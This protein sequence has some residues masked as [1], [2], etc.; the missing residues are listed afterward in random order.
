MYTRKLKLLANYFNI[1]KSNFSLKL[2]LFI[3][4]LT[5]GMF[6][7]FSQTYNAPYDI[8]RFQDFIGE[9]K[10]QA[11]TSSTAATQSD[12][13]NGYSSNW[14]YVVDTDKVAF[15]QSGSS[16]RTELRD[17]RNW[18]ITQG[19][20]SLFGR[21]D[22]VNQTCD[23]VTVLQI[24][25]DANAGSGPN[26]PL[27]RIYKHQNKSP[28]NHIWAAIKTDAGGA[29]TTHVDLGA[30]P[31]GYF[32]CEIKLVNGNMIINFDGVEKVNMDIS[33]WTFP[34]YWKAGV[35]LQDNG[36]ATAYFDQLYTG[37]PSGNI[38][39][40]VSISSPSNGTSFAEG[41][42]VTIN[43][44]AVDTDGTISQVEFFANGSSIGVDTSSP[45]ST[46][47]IIGL[48]SYDITAVATDNESLSTTSSIVTIT[49]NSATQNTDMYVSNI[50][51]GTQNAGKGSKYGIATVTILDGTGAPVSGA[52]VTGTFS[53]TFNET[54]SGIT[55]NNG[56]ITLIT[57]TT[58]KG[59]VSVDLCVDN[60]THSTLVYNNSLN[61]ITCTG[62]A[63]MLNV[64]S[65][66]SSFQSSKDLFDDSVIVYP[67][68]AT[69]FFEV[70]FLLEKENLFG[71]RVFGIDGREVIS[72]E[73]H[74]LSKDTH[75]MN[76]DI[77]ELNS[78]IYFL[79]MQIGQKILT[80]RI[81]KE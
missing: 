72:I 25:D 15:T 54:V 81:I 73:P 30:D 67:N 45:F 21:I 40:S 27:L 11:P 13:I 53:G 19:D 32:D 17:L 55:G 57:S 43:A 23:Q 79:E 29:N 31:G 80:R 33:Y 44:N 66:S 5:Q 38:P 18:N 78:G 2:T 20:Q 7:T 64:S 26:K 77:S 56:D 49:G 51:T 52:N 75:Q 1:Q 62:T 46:D 58:A 70:S 63:S 48:D 68:P 16:N 65:K 10:L 50:V 12:L 36:D 42:T 8:P 35:Y 41:D 60:V 37:T 39:P 9:C 59:G 22:I 3:F 4:C 14:F 61:V 34:S 47:W 74:L 76:I 28:L 69:T 6:V 71:A 24:H